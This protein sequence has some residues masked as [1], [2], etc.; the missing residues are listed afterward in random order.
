MKTRV[1]FIIALAVIGVIAVTG[2][3]VLMWRLFIALILVFLFSYLWVKLNARGLTA[4]VKTSARR[5]YAGD[6]INEE[7]N[8]TNNSSFPKVMLKIRESTSLSGQEDVT[9]VSISPRAARSWIRRVDC[10]RRGLHQIGSFFAYS[11][12][13]LNLFILNRRL[14]LSESILVYPAVVELPH[15]EPFGDRSLAG[16]SAGWSLSNEEGP[17]ASRVREYGANDRLTHIY[18]SATAHTGKLMVK[19]F[20]PDRSSYF[21]KYIWVVLDMREGQHF[22]KGE[23]ST[24]EYSIT[25]AASL[26]KK[27]M[28]NNNQVGLIASDD[29]QYFY[30]PTTGKRAY[31]EML[32][33][34]ALMKAAG[35]MSIDKFLLQG[36][37]Y[38]SAYSSIIVITPSAGERLLSALRLINNRGV[39]VCAILLDS[40]SFG[41]GESPQRTAANL[42][43]NGMQAFIVR[44]GMD[45]GKA[46]STRAG[47]GKSMGGSHA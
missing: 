5:C 31:E 42:A 8:V 2:G 47:T 11:S 1:L 38:F 19:E 43:M 46:L 6:S 24:E 41:G 45:I 33:E 28:G 9:T 40:S 15:F 35:K 3:F 22:G 16:I 34:L 39:H 26:L 20:D 23:D 21:S 25:I 29:R 12:D 4:T 17:S 14:T 13:P 7:I 27:Y 18:W 30:F 36:I 10:R 37:E 32:E 44:K